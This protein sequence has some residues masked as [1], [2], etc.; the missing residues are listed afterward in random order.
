[1]AVATR[2]ERVECYKTFD[3]LATCC[4]R[5]TQPRNQKGVELNVLNVV[6]THE[7]FIQTA[8]EE[9]GLLDHYANSVLLFAPLLSRA[10]VVSNTTPN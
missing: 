9:Q 8:K 1:M 7:Q 6:V 3:R 10:S 2:F 4:L 5:P